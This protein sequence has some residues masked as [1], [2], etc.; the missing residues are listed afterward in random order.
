MSGWSKGAVVVTGG[1]RGIGAAIVRGLAARG[2]PVCINHRDSAADAERLRIE[3]EAMGAEASVIKADIGSEADIV[4]LFE[5]AQQRH[6]RLWGLVNNAGFVGQAGRR[7]DEAD[8]RVL[9]ASF[10]VNAIGPILCTREMLRRISTRH[11]GLGGRIVNISSIAKRTGSPND[12]V[13]YAASK[14]ALDT[15]TLGVAREVATEG[16]QVNG[17]APGLV[18]TEIHARAGAPDRIER[19]SAAVP[20][21]RAGTPE[22]IADVAIWLLLEAPDYVHGTTIDVAGG[23]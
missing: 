18:A 19:M 12:W 11:G 17:V 2:V 5:E 23:V 1:S 21:K 9:E 20:M 14:G 8:A 3:A 15:F 13:D 22:D 6:G 4:A 7:V 16:V 10:R